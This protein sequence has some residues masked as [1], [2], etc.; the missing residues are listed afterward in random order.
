MYYITCRSGL[1]LPFS[2]FFF[3]SSPEVSFLKPGRGECGI[4]MELCFVGVEVLVATLV[5]LEKPVCI[6]VCVCTISM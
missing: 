5:E 6:Y 1:A 2:P 4:E 3:H